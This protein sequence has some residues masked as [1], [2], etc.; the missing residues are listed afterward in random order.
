[1]RSLFVIAALSVAALAWIPGC[2]DD[3]S[4]SA[5]SDSASGGVLDTATDT[6]EI[7]DAAHDVQHADSAIDGSLPTGEDALAEDV[8]TCSS[9]A[10]CPAATQ[11]CQRAACNK[12]VCTVIDRS[13]GAACPHPSE[14]VLSAT[15]QGGACTPVKQRNCDDGDPCTKDECTTIGLCSHAPV[16]G[17]AP[18]DD[19]NPCTKGETCDLKKGCN[20]GEK[21]CDC[22]SYEDCA[23][24]DDGDPCNG[25]LYCDP[26]TG[27]CALDPASLVL[28]STDK[29]G[30]CEVTACD[31]KLAACVTK[32]AKS[33]TPCEDGN[34][35]TL[36]EAC[37][38]LGNCAGD[39]NICG[40]ESHADCSPLEDGNPCNGTL[41]CN[42]IAPPYSCQVDPSSVVICDPGKD[43]ACTANRCDKTTGGCAIA[44]ANQGGTCDDGDKCSKGDV[45]VDGACSSGTDVCS[46]KVNAD[47]ASEEDGDLC[48]GTLFCN[49]LTHLCEL[50]PKT[51]IACPSVDDTQCT[52]NTCQKKTGKCLSTAV[53]DGSECDDA[54]KCSTG[55][56]CMAGQCVGSANTCQCQKAE[57][58]AGK[59]DGDLCNGV[60]F[61]NQKTG[62]CEV[63]PATIKSCPSV[64]NTA[65]LVN[66]C[67]S[68]S[69]SCTMTAAAQNSACDADGSACTVGDHCKDGECVAGTNTC[70]C[71][72]DSDCLGQEDGDACNGT[73]FC[74]ISTGSC[75]LNPS[76][77]IV[78][79]SVDN[80]T[81]AAN[82]CDKK[83]GKCGV[84]AISNGLGCDDGN[85]CT[86]SDTCLAGKCH[87]TNICECAS[88]QD[89]AAKDPNDPCTG[90]L[91]CDKSGPSNRCRPNPGKG[92]KCSAA[93]DTPCRKSTCD[94]KTGKCALKAINELVV[95]GPGTLCSAVKICVA[96][97]C[98]KG[99]PLNCND[100]NPCTVDSCDDFAGCQHKLE[101]AVACDD[102]NK[103]TSDD[104]CV[105]GFCTGTS[106]DCDDGT[107]CTQDVCAPLHGCQHFAKPGKCDD[108]DA[109]TIG[110]TCSDGV[111]VSGKPRVCQDNNPCTKDGCDA[112]EGCVYKG[113]DKACDDGDKC[114]LADKCVSGICLPGK[115]DD[116]DDGN[117]CTTDSCAKDK[118]CSH[119]GVAD[120]DGCDDGDLCTDQDTCAGGKCAAKPLA[121]DDDNACTADSCDKS[122]GTCVFTTANT[123]KPCHGV[124]TCSLGSCVDGKRGRVRV[125]AGPFLMGCDDDKDKNCDKD[126]FPQ[127]Q[128]TLKAYWI[129]LH[130]VS[131]GRY[132]SCVSAGGCKLPPLGHKQSA[133]FPYG[134]PDDDDLPM[135]GLNAAM[136]AAFC[137]HHGGGLPTEAQW[138]KAA[139]GGCSI[140]PEGDCAKHT[141]I[142]PHGDKGA[143]CAVAV[144]RT[145]VD[146]NGCG[147]NSYHDVGS[148]PAGGSPYGV[149]DLAGNVAEW[150]ADGYAE[151]YYSVA[152]T[153]D[154]PGPANPEPR[155]IRGGSFYGDTVTLRATNRS[156]SLSDFSAAHLGF[157]CAYP[158][159]V[160][161][162]GNACTTDKLD[163]K[164]GKCVHAASD[165]AVCSDGDGC[166]SNDSCKAGK[167]AAGA[168]RDCSDGQPC[169]TDACDSKTGLCQHAPRKD[170]A[171]C[172]EGS[173]SCK[174]GQCYH[175]G[176]GQVLVP[177]GAFAMGCN[178][179]LEGD[180]CGPDE[181]PQR[182]IGVN[183][184]WIDRTEVTKADYRECVDAGVCKPPRLA[185][186]EA[187]KDPSHPRNNWTQLGRAQHPINC[188]TRDEAAAFCTW[189]GGSL[190]TEAEWEKTARGAMG[191]HARSTP[192]PR[193]RARGGCWTWPATC[194]IGP[195]T[196]TAP[197][198]TRA[199]LRPTRK[200]PAVGSSG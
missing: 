60:V 88:D 197:A 78:C 17:G 19:G 141:P 97:Q 123:G 48:N 112:L 98:Q 110:D 57:D 103:C 190:P 189:R 101:N 149:Q 53:A 166:T 51:T 96:G 91:Y 47:C 126:E 66:T 46:C 9:T 22:D 120:G 24:Q 65:C 44:A 191:G 133:V 54:N 160:C 23:L 35:C 104:I 36:D 25:S 169:T 5:N 18:C 61:C 40:C 77:V 93:Q 20:G 68:L 43:T 76:T 13:E 196:G 83:S 79:P 152:P 41:F 8:L 95:C 49:K 175:V 33:G 137:A 124:G 117:D 130:E 119:A 142:W 153:H 159:I 59:D 186:S 178:R 177:G 127:R 34:P 132:R 158:S 138:E 114:T 56:H 173:E 4:P 179:A 180:E 198:I 89:C 94:S 38:P 121:C 188:I 107:P 150:V 109:C 162:D 70:A 108:S 84:T 193:A 167:C 45:C 12:G 118:G 31:P 11:P 131:V 164:T 113:L 99:K 10:D 143:T 129:D 182:T 140:Y 3:P 147:T 67:V 14:C 148:K 72:A 7:V 52:K 154:P 134:A 199:R 80:T 171:P 163:S 185:G 200:A 63:N 183:T 55:D 184:F 27:T 62:K 1:M 105:Q 176:R 16:G 115:E 136:S 42:K 50:D 128:V 92:V 122:A 30:P 90:P 58:C 125:P 87:G 187:C 157:R 111:C 69:G 64:G 106:V 135:T 151:Q 74:N 192:S 26:Q 6:G 165:G 39:K 81:C 21:V 139:R 155:V 2:S 100:G 86:A 28:C 145:E 71:K 29:D 116:C 168:P 161:D 37:D 174:A 82:T 102:A 195:P 194:T 32:P 73:L 170:G 172:G 181:R 156:F 75:Q 146:G 15:C 85:P 144:M